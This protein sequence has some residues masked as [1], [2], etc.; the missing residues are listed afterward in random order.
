MND[1]DRILELHQ[2]AIVVDSHCDTIL[3]WMGV[4]LYTG[5]N[6]GGLTFGERNTKGQMDIPRM[7][8]G[9][10]DAQIFAVYTQPQFKEGPLALKRAMQMIDVFQTEIGKYPD[11]VT[12]AKKTDDIYKAE[13]E[14]KIAALLSLEGG[15]P[16]C[17]DLGV[18]RMMHRIGV[19]CITL[20]WNQRNMIADGVGERR[21]NSGLTNFGVQVVEEMN[22]LG[23]LVDV[24]HLSDSGFDD[25][26]ATTKKPI[27]ASHSNCRSL[28]NHP[29]NLTDDQ[30][31]AI[32]ENGGIIGIVFAPGFID[33]DPAKQTVTRLLD[34]IDHIRDLVG[35]EHIGIGSDFDG[36][37][38]LPKGLEDVTKMPNITKGLLEKGYSETDVKKI[39]GENYLRIFKEVIG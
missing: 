25:V 26:I 12:F 35:L 27:I 20:T 1:D 11:K 33:R 29:R 3:Q 31:Q 36:F 39:L 13:K 37:P 32:G 10:V 4:D 28:S 24:A 34:H 9:G 22:R 38:G 19:R 5:S 17:G 18:L 6:R 21:T 14:G 8:E 7:N 23:M 30:I 2:E 15:E 16:L